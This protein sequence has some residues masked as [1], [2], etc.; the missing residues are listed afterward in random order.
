MAWLERTLTESTAKFRLIVSPTPLVGPDRDN[1]HDNY[2]NDV[3]ATEGQEVRKLLASYPN[4]VSIC[5]DRHW[6]YHSI[7]PK[8]GLHEF[9]VGPASDRHAGGWDPKDY[10]EGI[11]QFLR[12]AGG[13]LEIE[14][15]G[16]EQSPT[17]T[18]RHLDTQGAE[19]HRHV[20]K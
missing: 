5:G 15:A 20:L 18:L 1:K 16:G 19:H 14:L 12:V 2:S 13:Y 11:H 8:T 9:S 17:L 4:L 6:Q 7:D 10:R 3:F